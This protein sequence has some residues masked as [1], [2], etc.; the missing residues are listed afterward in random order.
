MSDLAKI[1]SRLSEIVEIL[2]WLVDEVRK[3]NEGMERT[4]DRIRARSTRK[5]R[6]RVS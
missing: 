4:A 2:R 6:R 3:G 5:Q 1:E